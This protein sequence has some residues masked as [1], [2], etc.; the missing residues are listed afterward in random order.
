MTVPVFT[1]DQFIEYIK[2]NGWEIVSTDYWDEYNRLIFGKDGKSI[3]FQCEE[4]YFY[5]AVVRTCMIFQIPIPED[6]NHQ[7]YLHHKMYDDVCYCGT[8]LAFKE[9]HGKQ[10]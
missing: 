10:Q 9:C 3:T 6:H 1:Q 8:Q 7:F 5:I 4:R 2:S